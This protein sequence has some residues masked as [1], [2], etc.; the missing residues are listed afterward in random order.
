[1]S[2]GGFDKWLAIAWLPQ[3]DGQPYHVSEGDSGGPTAW[4]ITWGT[5][6]AW[7]KAHGQKT[8]FLS[9]LQAATKDELS[10]ILRTWFWNAVQ[11]DV[12]PLGLDLMVAE[13]AMLSGSGTAARVLQGVLGVTADG[14]IGPQTLGAA[15]AADPTA[16]VTAFCD[17]YVAHVN[18][19]A[20]AATFRGGWDRR[21]DDDRVTA[22]GWL[23]GADVP[24]DSAW[25]PVNAGATT[26]NA[27][28]TADGLNDAEL[29]DL[30]G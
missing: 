28:D 7:R 13:G 26:V 10:L 4:G 11:G 23:G 24:Q 2:A 1:M 8:P 15:G 21:I 30:A 27:L 29:Q 12:L 22:L 6:V 16:N 18:A 17:A 3:N 19:L 20:D 5:F 9:D 25:Q 14:A